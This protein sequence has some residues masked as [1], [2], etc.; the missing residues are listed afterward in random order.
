[1]LH[2]LRTLIQAKFICLDNFGWTVLHISHAQSCKGLHLK[3]LH[4]YYTELLP[5]SMI[6]Y[7]YMYMYIVMSCR[8][9]YIKLSI[10]CCRIFGAYTG[11]REWSGPVPELEW[12]PAGPPGTHWQ[13]HR[14]DVINDDL[15]Y[16]HT[17]VYRSPQNFISFTHVVILVGY[18][19]L[20]VKKSMFSSPLKS[21]DF[22]RDW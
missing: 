3:L 6:H 22:P 20:T 15:I 13:S 19:F 11:C 5:H 21:I 16:E 8:V 18:F 2:I 7:M 17:C 14:D 10:W 12:A 1:M 9:Q 4:P